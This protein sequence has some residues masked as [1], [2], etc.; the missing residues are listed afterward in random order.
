MGAGIF[1]RH[2]VLA[3]HEP[4]VLLISPVLRATVYNFLSPS[5]GDLAVLSYNDLQID[6]HVEVVDALKLV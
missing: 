5:V 2:S 3:R 1:L 6:A 4:A